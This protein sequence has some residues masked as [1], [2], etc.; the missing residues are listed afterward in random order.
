MWAENRRLDTKSCRY[1]SFRHGLKHFLGYDLKH[2][3]YSKISI[4]LRI[5]LRENEKNIWGD[6]SSSFKPSTRN[7]VHLDWTLTCI[8]TFM[9]S[10]ELHAQQSETND[11]NITMYFPFGENLLSWL[12]CLKSSEKFILGWSNSAGIIN[13]QITTWY[14]HK[15]KAKTYKN[16]KI[17]RNPP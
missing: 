14:S 12:V 16:G 6:Y 1:K 17:R 11:H 9:T 10:C 3:S 2:R 4:T 8:E 7:Y 13:W 5:S 15:N